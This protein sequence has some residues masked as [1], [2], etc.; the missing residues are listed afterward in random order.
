[1]PVMSMTLQWYSPGIAILDIK[2][3]PEADQDFSFFSISLA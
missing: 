3:L 1:M 2:L